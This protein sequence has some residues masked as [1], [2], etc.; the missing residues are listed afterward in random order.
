MHEP[1]ILSHAGMGDR[2]FSFQLAG[3]SSDNCDCVGQR[4]TGSKAGASTLTGPDWEGELP[5]SVESTSPAPTPWTLC[6]G[7]TR[8]DG[9]DDPAAVRKLQ[10]QCQLTPLSLWGQSDATAPERRD[11]LNPI[12]MTGI[13]P[14]RARAAGVLTR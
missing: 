7:R 9:P 6:L 3:M 12:E 11:V 10:S 5:T 2:H 8:V 1:M 4:T 13:G 14:A